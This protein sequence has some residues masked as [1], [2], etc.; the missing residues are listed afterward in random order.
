A[1]FVAARRTLSRPAATDRSR[2][3]R[4]A[5]SRSGDQC[6][7]S[8]RRQD[9]A[10]AAASSRDTHRPTSLLSRH[11]NAPGLSHQRVAPSGG[12]RS[13][14]RST[15]G[16]DR[17]RS[18]GRIVS[19]GIMSTPFKEE[20]WSGDFEFD[21][22]MAESEEA[23]T[24]WESEF[25]RRPGPWRRAARTSPPWRPGAVRPPSRPGAVR[26]PSR[27]GAASQPWRYGTALQP[28]RYGTALQPWRFGTTQ[29]LQSASFRPWWRRPRRP[30]RPFYFRT[31][32]PSWGGWLGTAEP[33]IDEPPIDE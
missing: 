12:H 9:S 17:I 21:T 8:R 27:Y 25:H 13:R 20:G 24:E 4:W 30:R 28:W 19:E 26:P 29:P 11:R 3:A 18:S 6:A 10:P 31:T 14:D 2:G 33:P 32:L 5:L 1:L 22:E 16:R 15:R 23:E 7:R